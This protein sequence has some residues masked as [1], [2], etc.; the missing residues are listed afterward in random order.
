V[1]GNVL[2][3]VSL[4]S[5]LLFAAMIWVTRAGPKRAMATLVS[6]ITVTIFSLA[7]DALAARMG[8]WTYALEG[9]LLTTLALSMNIAFLFGGVAALCGWR[10]MRAM[11]WTGAFTFFF[12]FV[13]IG[14][15]RDQLLQA[16]TTVLDY[17][18]GPMPQ[19]MAGVGYLSM[20]LIVQI[21]MLVLAGPPTRDPLRQTI[22][23]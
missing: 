2:L 21:T 14:L 8:W 20:A 23:E 13:G 17:G 9:N 7:W 11:G 16:N 3:A 22:P 19:V 12:A 10:A 4:V 18:A 6:C 5:P 15:L 1:I